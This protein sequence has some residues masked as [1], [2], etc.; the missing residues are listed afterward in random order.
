MIYLDYASS[1]PLLP[2]VLNLFDH[3]WKEHFANPASKHRLGKSSEK[4]INTLRRDFLKELGSPKGS[5]LFLSSITEANNQIIKGLDLNKTEILY[6]KGDHSSIVV[7]IENRNASWQAVAVNHKEDGLID[8]DDLYSKISSTTSL[9]FF[10]HV[11]SQSGMEQISFKTLKKIKQKFPKIKIALDGAQSFSKRDITLAE[12]CIDFFSFS[13]HKIGGPKGIAGLYMKE[14][15]AP[16]IEG[17]AQ[18][19]GL[20][21]STVATPLVM[22]MHQAMKVW[23]AQRVESTKRFIAFKT[24]IKQKI[25]KKIP[26]ALFP[27]LQLETSS[28]FTFIL[29]DISSDILMR[30]LEMDEIYISS[31]S[32]C[33]SKSK[34]GNSVLAS[35]QIPTKLQKGVLRVSFG[36][37]TTEQEID[38]FVEKVIKHYLDLIKYR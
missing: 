28:I 26:T 23:S 12:G 37:E 2:E 11:N 16:L 13:S 8:E 18:E 20:R 5:L 6:S 27:F 19:D 1:T 10:S 30:H 38:F 3:C 4:I 33:S 9:I 22:G 24:I 35:L 29:P 15:L 14:R 36:I 31:T 17:G 34:L 7:P 32:A 25:S 21:S